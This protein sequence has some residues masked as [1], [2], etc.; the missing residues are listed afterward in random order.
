VLPGAERAALD[1]RVCVTDRL[2]QLAA[3]HKRRI[4]DLVRQLLPL[5]PLTGDLSA[6]DLA[7]L[8]RHVDPRAKC[9]HTTQR[10]RPAEPVTSLGTVPI[11]AG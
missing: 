5:S 7:V 2:T 9:S 8:E 3:G 6:A 11:L 1:R 10:C 4:K